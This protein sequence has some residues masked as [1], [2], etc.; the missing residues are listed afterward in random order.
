MP[1]CKGCH[2]EIV[3]GRDEKGTAIPLDPRAPVYK[4][5]PVGANGEAEITR[6]HGA[7][8][9]HFAT[10]SHANEFGKGRKS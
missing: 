4:L 9:S 2:K 6:D 1:Q 7:M 10:C 8:V 3:W 5:G